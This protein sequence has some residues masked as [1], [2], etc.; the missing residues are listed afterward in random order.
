[1]LERWMRKIRERMR[2]FEL[3]IRDFEGMLVY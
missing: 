3:M 1:M 2:F